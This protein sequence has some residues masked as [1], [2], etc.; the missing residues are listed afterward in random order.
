MK[1]DNFFLVEGTVIS[2]LT[3]RSRST[4]RLFPRRFFPPTLVILKSERSV[5]ERRNPPWCKK[6]IYS[7]PCDDLY[8]DQD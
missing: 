4:S 2:F 1:V 3:R 6:P 8:R 7:I 5:G